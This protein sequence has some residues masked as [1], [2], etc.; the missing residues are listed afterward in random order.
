MR[1]VCLK[2]GCTLDSRRVIVRLNASGP[3]KVKKGRNGRAVAKAADENRVVVST[4]FKGKSK[5]SV[6]G[7]SKRCMHGRQRSRCKVLASLFP[8]T[9]LPSSELE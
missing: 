8:T 3:G 7:K 1:G 9:L 6:H 2:M 4:K 5:R